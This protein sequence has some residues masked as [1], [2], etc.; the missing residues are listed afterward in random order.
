MR[1]AQEAQASPRS[2][3]SNRRTWLAMVNNIA[4]AMSPEVERVGR[5]IN[6]NLISRF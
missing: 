1:T 5:F 3:E 6:S 4:M 2:G